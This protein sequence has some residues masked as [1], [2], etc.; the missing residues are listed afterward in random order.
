MAIGWKLWSFSNSPPNDC[1]ELIS[2]R[3]DWFDLLAIQGTLESFLAPQFKG[4][5]SSALS[6]L[7]GAAF[8]SVH[9]SWE[10][11]SFD[12]T[13]RRGQVGDGAYPLWL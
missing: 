6:L 13:E 12:Y 5:S 3:I 9:D 7:Y 11:H 10:N 4:F 1:A 2:F 8:T